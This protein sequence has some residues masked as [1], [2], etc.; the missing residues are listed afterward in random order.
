MNSLAD[1][2]LM[3]QVKAGNPDKMSLLFER[4][5]RALYA[6]L[7][8]MTYKREASEDMV[9]N[10]FY[11]MLKYSSTFKGDGEFVYWMYHIARNV[12]NEWVRKN[13]N[14]TQQADFAD[15]EER[16]GS[17]GS[18]EEAYEK[19]EAKTRLYAAMARLS[20]DDREIITLSRFQELKHQEVAQILGISEGAAKVRVHRALQE[21]KCVFLKMNN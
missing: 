16:M 14:H 19:K 4:H 7:F 11:R 10:V 5:N 20:D 3:L 12:L 6:F 17:G 18:V 21:L 15:I 8:H 9:Q 1:N 13:K 2:A